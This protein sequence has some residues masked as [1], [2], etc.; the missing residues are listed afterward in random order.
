MRIL[1]TI[2]KKAQTSRAAETSA[3]DAAQ[4]IAQLQQIAMLQDKATRVIEAAEAALDQSLRDCPSLDEA[5]DGT[6]RVLRTAH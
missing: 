1:E 3:P 2:A 6:L 5:G 4:R